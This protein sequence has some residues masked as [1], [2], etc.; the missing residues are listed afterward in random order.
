M[1]GIGVDIVEFARIEAIKNKEKFIDKILSTK[2]KAT[3]TTLKNQKRQLEYLAGR[4]AVK[5]AIYKAA[6]D[7][8]AGKSFTDF[9]ILN[10]ESG[11]PYLDEPVAPGIMITL[12][13]SENY[14]VAVVVNV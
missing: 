6:F 1:Q 8:C 9:S 2:E 5:E 13:H 4:W 7:L 3:Y 14:V 10:H 12:S 11:A